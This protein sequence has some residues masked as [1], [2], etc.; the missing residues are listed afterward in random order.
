M[1]THVYF[2]GLV[3]LVG[4]AVPALATW[5]MITRNHRTDDDDLRTYG[6]WWDA[7]GM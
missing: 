7:L 5:A 3:L 2:R 1:I 6:E 4:I